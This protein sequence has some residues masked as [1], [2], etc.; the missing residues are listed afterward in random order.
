ML[1]IIY[2]KEYKRLL[3][4]YTVYNYNHCNSPIQTFRCFFSLQIE[5]TGKNISSINQIL[6][7]M[8]VNGFQLTSL[9][10]SSSVILF[11]ADCLPL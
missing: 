1:A 2:K 7:R 11:C 3:I 10:P 9:V 6:S 5:F 4:F 8:S